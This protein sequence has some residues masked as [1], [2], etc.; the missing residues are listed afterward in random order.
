M[1]WT[2]FFKSNPFT[3][4]FRTGAA[5]LILGTVGTVHIALKFASEC[6]AVVDSCDAAVGEDIS[7]SEL[8]ANLE[9]HNHSTTITLHDISAPFP[10]GLTDIINQLNELPVLCFYGPLAIGLGVTIAVSLAIASTIA[11]AVHIKE[12][13]ENREEDGAYLRLPNA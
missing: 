11:V 12:H 3:Y 5:T 7:V 6:S 8:T 10:E 9:I 13:D 4:G 2:A 1:T